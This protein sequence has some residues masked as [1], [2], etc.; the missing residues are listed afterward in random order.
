MIQNEC[1][2]LIGGHY[3]R[4]FPSFYAWRPAG[5]RRE[6]CLSNVAN[7]YRDLFWP[8]IRGVAV[9]SNGMGSVRRSEM[10][11]VKAM[12]NAISILTDG[13]LAHPPSVSPF[14]PTAHK[15][16][17]S[18]DVYRGTYLGFVVWEAENVNLGNFDD[19]SL[20]GSSRRRRA[21]LSR[22]A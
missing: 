18:G 4:G 5:R 21:P 12:E 17:L 1:E 20:F 19:R 14:L 9:K 10:V 8:D 6:I 16:L 2:I 22:V 11:S 13:V 3:K 15:Y 7:V